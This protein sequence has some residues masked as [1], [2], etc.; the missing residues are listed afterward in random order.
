MEQGILIECLQNIDHILGYK[1]NIS[2]FYN[3]EIL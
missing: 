2:K 1:V 3:V